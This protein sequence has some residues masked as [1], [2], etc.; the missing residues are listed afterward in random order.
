MA[1]PILDPDYWHHRM[2]AAPKGEDHRA[3]FLCPK[4][5]WD[6]IE[7]VHRA[8]LCRHIKPNTSIFDAG[9]GW[10][11]LLDMLPLEWMGAYLGVD[12]SPDFIDKARRL[13]QYPRRGRDA[14]F[15]VGNL[16]NLSL[17]TSSDKADLAI[18]ISIKPMVVRNLGAEAWDLMEAQ[19]RTVAKSI[20]LLEYDETD[21]GELL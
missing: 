13:H 1:E 10:G 7:L 18:C 20:L 17:F 12:L 19:L 6:K 16:M 4:E 3:V 9:C 14:R 5:S 15:H 11:R 8:I 21:E 2:M